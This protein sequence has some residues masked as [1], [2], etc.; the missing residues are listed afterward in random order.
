MTPQ[1]DLKIKRLYIALGVVAPKDVTPDNIDDY[2]VKTPF[3]FGVDFNRNAN[4][5]EQMDTLQRAVSNVASIK[6]Y[7]KSWCKSNGQKE[8]LVEDVINNNQSVAL[9]HDLWNIDKHET[10]NRPPRSGVTPHIEI[11]GNA[12]QMGGNITTDV[13][14]DGTTIRGGGVVL[15]ADVVDEAGNKLGHFHKI[16]EEAI[17][18]WTVELKSAGVPISY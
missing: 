10:L 15:M 1:F 16:C 6:D 14:K 18:V 12:F 7:F 5:V 11:I 17:D 2:V 9:I 4:E 8:S 13:E 3:S